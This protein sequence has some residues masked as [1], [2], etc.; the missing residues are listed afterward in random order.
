MER[1]GKRKDSV[2]W[3]LKESDDQLLNESDD[4]SLLGGGIN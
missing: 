2:G 4:R 3:K 1:R